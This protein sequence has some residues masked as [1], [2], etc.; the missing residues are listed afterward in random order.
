[1]A[2]EQ[3]A[4]ALPPTGPDG[5]LLHVDFRITVFHIGKV[6]TREQTSLVRMGIVLYWTDPRM[7]GWSSPILPPTLWGPELWLRNAMGGVSVELEQFVVFNAEE[8]RLKRVLNYEATIITPMNLESFPFDLQCLSPEWASIW[9]ADVVLMA[10]AQCLR[11]M[12]HG[13]GSV[14]THLARMEVT[15]HTARNMCL[16]PTGLDLPLEAA[17]WQP[18]RLASARAELQACADPPQERGRFPHDVLPREGAL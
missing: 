1:M 13:D 10:C 15:R 7:V 12:C 6:D 14:Q 2:D 11:A 17:R 3:D 18:L 4:L 16:Y 9:V 8:G 5:A